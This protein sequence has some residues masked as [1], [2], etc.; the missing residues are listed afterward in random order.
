M[1]V[2]EAI[3]MQFSRRLEVEKVDI[4]S[5]LLEGM[6]KWIEKPCPTL[7][8]VASEGAFTCYIHM[9]QTKWGPGRIDSSIEGS[10]KSPA[11]L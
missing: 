5:L 4:D 10:D 7:E 2:H 8:N 1:K 9:M 6:G 11:F 3:S